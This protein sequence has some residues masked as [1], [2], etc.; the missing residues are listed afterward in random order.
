MLLSPFYASNIER[1]NMMKTIAVQSAFNES[2][3]ILCKN[4]AEQAD[5]FETCRALNLVT[6]WD[7]RQDCTLPPTEHAQVYVEYTSMFNALS[8][9]ERHLPS[10]CAF[11]EW[12]DLILD[13][14]FDTSFQY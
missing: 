14:P 1:R 2:L 10:W 9:W 13:A 12:S 3:P 5:L 8:L 4:R 7:D 11:V 6:I